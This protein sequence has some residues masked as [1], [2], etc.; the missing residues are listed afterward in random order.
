VMMEILLMEMDVMQIV[1]SE[2]I[3]VVQLHLLIK[4]R[5]L[6]YVLVLVLLVSIMTQLLSPVY[7]VIILVELVLVHPFV[8]HVLQ[9]ATEYL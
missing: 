6:H 2:I 4:I 9:S 5:L 8:T 3:T 1:L 7:L